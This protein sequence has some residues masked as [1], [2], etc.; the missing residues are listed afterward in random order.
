MTTD[1]EPS[2]FWVW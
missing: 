1:L 2:E